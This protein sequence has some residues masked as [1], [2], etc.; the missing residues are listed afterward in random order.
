[1]AEVEI[2]P[3]Y[4]K[5]AMQQP[6]VVAQL[7]VVADRVALKARSIA[8]G[9]GADVEV[10]TKAGVRPQ[11]RP[12]VDVVMTNPAAEWGAHGAARRRILG[13]AAQAG[14]A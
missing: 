11:G 6:G 7:Q 2:T 1:M 4:I 13:R 14:A 3:A 9:E 8:A 12:F 5:S 10:S